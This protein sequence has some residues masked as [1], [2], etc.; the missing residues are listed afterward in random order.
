M[1][2]KKA[3]AQ[4]VLGV[5]L[6]SGC[7]SGISSI[8]KSID[9]YR[10]VVKGT[11]LERIEEI[12]RFFEQPFLNVKNISQELKD[13]RARLLDKR[14]RLLDNPKIKMR[15]DYAQSIK[16][17]NIVLK[18]LGSLGLCYAGVGFSMAAGYNLKRKQN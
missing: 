15:Y 4:G 16:P 1:S 11:D 7:F 8:V 2:L 9:R 14:A 12:D 5:A 13:E 6:I 10:Q 17:N 3:I 18:Y